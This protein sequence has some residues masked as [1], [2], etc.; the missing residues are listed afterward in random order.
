MEFFEKGIV[1]YFKNDKLIESDR[2]VFARYGKSCNGTLS[3]NEEFIIFLHNN[4]EDL[5]A[6]FSGGVCDTM[7]VVLRG[8][9]FEIYE[10]RCEFYSSL[11]TKQ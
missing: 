8:F 3:Q 10:D 6:Y 1:K 7:I 9:P 5:S 11:F 4:N 2:L